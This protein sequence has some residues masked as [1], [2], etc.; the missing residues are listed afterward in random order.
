[1]YWSPKLVYKLKVRLDG[2]VKWFIHWLIWCMWCYRSAFC[3][4]FLLISTFKY[5]LLETWYFVTV[6]LIGKWIICSLWCDQT[7]WDMVKGLWCLESSSVELLLWSHRFTF[8]NFTG[9]FVGYCCVARRCTL[10]HVFSYQTQFIHIHK[11]T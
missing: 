8:L 11:Y 2:L 3:C 1:M 4:C 7:K 6:V 10:K 5:F 9:F